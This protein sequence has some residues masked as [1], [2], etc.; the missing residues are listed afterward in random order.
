MTYDLTNLDAKVAAAKTE[1]AA[2]FAVD[3][4]LIHIT[5]AKRNRDTTTPG[6]LLPT[7]ELYYTEVTFELRLPGPGL[8]AELDGAAQE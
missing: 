2:R 8:Q 3:P 5:A 6:A 1:L 4:S 7:T